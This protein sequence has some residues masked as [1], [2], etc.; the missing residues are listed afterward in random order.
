MIGVD[1]REMKRRDREGKGSEVKAGQEGESL[2]EKKGK[3][4]T[5]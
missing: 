2:N 3:E 1:E 5:R 4:K